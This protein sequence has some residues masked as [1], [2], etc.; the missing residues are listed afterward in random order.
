[1]TTISAQ[2]DNLSLP[3]SGATVTK[4]TIVVPFSGLADG[5]LPDFE[6]MLADMTQDLAGKDSKK[7]DQPPSAELGELNLPLLMIVDILPKAVVQSDRVAIQSSSAEN[8]GDDSFRK[9]ARP[10]D[11]APLLPIDAERDLRGVNDAGASAALSN[12]GPPSSPR[13]SSSSSPLRSQPIKPK[14]LLAV[15]QTHGRI[16]HGLMEL[17]NSSRIEEWRAQPR[18]SETNAKAV[19]MPDSADAVPKKQSAGP[20]LAVE[21]S[22]ADAPTFSLPIHVSR[23]ET[24]LPAALV[25]TVDEL[26]APVKQSGSDVVG[27]SPVEAQPKERLKI[28]TFDLHP[29]RLGPVTVRMRMSGG[30]VEIAIDVRSE[31]A[32]SALNR[33]SGAIVEALAGHGLTLDPPDI[34]LATSPTAMEPAP[35]MNSQNGFVGADSFA[36]GQGRAHHEEKPAFRQHEWPSDQKS[37]AVQSGDTDPGVVSGVY[38]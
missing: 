13:P 12:S 20:Q 10:E 35:L 15:A 18:K 34:R 30:H 29:E 25:Q 37:G 26:S 23:L 31:D 8:T 3:S 33:T 38:L 16:S 4:S 32:R 27:S 7:E 6:D 22:P 1:M 9:T 11:G 24:H 36:Q 17:I 19:T 14:D 21:G 28:L 2:S 5:A